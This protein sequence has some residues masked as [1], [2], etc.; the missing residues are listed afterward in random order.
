MI[1]LEA[2]MLVHLNGRIHLYKAH[3]ATGDFQEGTMPFLTCIDVAV[4][5]CTWLASLVTKSKP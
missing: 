3:A 4:G 5:T 2:I 1:A